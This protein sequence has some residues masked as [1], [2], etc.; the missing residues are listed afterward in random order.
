MQFMFWKCV[1]KRKRCYK[2]GAKVLFFGDAHI[3][4][5]SWFLHVYHYCKQSD[6]EGPEREQ[7][8]LVFEEAKQQNR[9]LRGC[10]QYYLAQNT[11]N[12]H[13]HV[14]H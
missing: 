12:M 5:H 7:V 3:L 4:T 1:W 2:E 13:D 9:G 10:L 6:L 8:R 11:A 14:P